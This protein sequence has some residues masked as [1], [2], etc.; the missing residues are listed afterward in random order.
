MPTKT[1]FDTCSKIIFNSLLILHCHRYGVW[2]WENCRRAR[3]PT[4]I[5]AECMPGVGVQIIADNAKT[6]EL[7]SK[8][9]T[10]T[11]LRGLFQNMITC[12]NAVR[13]LKLSGHER[14]K[15]KESIMKANRIENDPTRKQS[16]FETREPS[17]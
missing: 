7:K 3:K 16:L 12:D 10:I 1:V 6:L 5:K 17:F 11:R 15:W 9:Y 13:R 8:G 4:V 14:S 2:F